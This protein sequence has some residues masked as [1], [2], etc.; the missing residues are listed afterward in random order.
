M[1]SCPNLVYILLFD[2]Y[3]FNLLPVCF[4]YVCLFVL[5]LYGVVFLPGSS[6]GLRINYHQPVPYGPV[7]TSFSSP[8][9]FPSP[10]PSQPF[11]RFFIF[12]HCHYHHFSS[13]FSFISCL[14]LFSFPQ[15][16]T[17]L[18]PILF[19]ITLTPICKRVSRLGCPVNLVLFCVALGLKVGRSWRHLLLIW[20]LQTLVFFLN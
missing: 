14:D 8:S 17:W 16:M 11:L 6:S 5:C 12:F 10:P 4:F 9:P 18:T 13:F 15:D 20:S 1:L 2:L 19:W 3:Y 7:L